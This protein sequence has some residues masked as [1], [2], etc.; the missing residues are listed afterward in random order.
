MIAI[1]TFLK[2]FIVRHQNRKGFWSAASKPR[3]PVVDHRILAATGNRL[4]RECIDRGLS[5]WQ[6]DALRGRF[7]ADAHRVG[8]LEAYADCTERAC[9]MALEAGR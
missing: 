2:P 5:K 1:A 3:V 9:E 8:H 4:H 6:A 7:M